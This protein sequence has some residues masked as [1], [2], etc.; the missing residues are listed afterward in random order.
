MKR[1]VDIKAK[2]ISNWIALGLPGVEKMEKG[3]S[4]IGGGPYSKYLKLSVHFANSVVL[5]GK[6]SIYK[7]ERLQ[8]FIVWLLLIFKLN[9]SKA[10]FEFEV[11]G[12]E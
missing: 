7:I 9:D 2:K 1:S 10:L 8:M 3:N 4:S 6:Y 5:K 12:E 11:N